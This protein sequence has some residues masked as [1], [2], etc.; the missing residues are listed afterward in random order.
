MIEV[1]C[2]DTA[3][4]KNKVP[5]KEKEIGKVRIICIIRQSRELDLPTAEQFC[6]DRCDVVV[7]DMEGYNVKIFSAGWRIILTC[8][9]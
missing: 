9:L 8:F 3:I 2:K 4:L 7:F 5:D 1:I 6:M